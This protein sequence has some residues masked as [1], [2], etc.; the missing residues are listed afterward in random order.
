MLNVYSPKDVVSAF[1]GINMT[2]YAEDGFIS[3]SRN[4][5]LVTEQFGAQSDLQLNVV[6]ANGGTIEIVLLQNSY[7]NKEFEKLYNEH[8]GGATPVV[9]TFTLSDPNQGVTIEA[10]NVYLKTVSDYGFGLESTDRTW[11]LGCES[12][13]ITTVE[14]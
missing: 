8:I 10:I 14:V 7:T 1:N 6:T 11:T 12:Y 4:E 13:T 2:G 5:D 3:I 9:G